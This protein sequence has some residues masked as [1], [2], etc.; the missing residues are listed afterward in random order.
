M[1][2]PQHS[3]DARRLQ[4]A[5]RH[6]R[7]IKAADYPQILPS[8]EDRQGPYRIVERPW[9]QIPEGNKLAIL[10]DAVDWSG[11]TNRDQAAL[12]LAAI[13][14]TQ[15]NDADRNRL[16]DAAAG[17]APQPHSSPGHSREAAIT[18][19]LAKQF[20][21]ARPRPQPQC[22]VEPERSR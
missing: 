5:Q 20:G 13:D 10:R 1:T 18:G 9:A 11:I 14:P 2:A 19:T 22:P 21:P 6:I 7:Q 8:T 4:E 15:I 12:L 16:I 3:S 17:A